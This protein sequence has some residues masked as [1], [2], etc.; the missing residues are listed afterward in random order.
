MDYVITKKQITDYCLSLTAD[1]KSVGTINKY[2]R[3]VTAFARWLNGRG[4]TKETASGWKAHMKE[5]GYAPCTINSMLAAINGFFRFMRWGLRVK[6]LKIQRQ[7]FR[8]TA[9]ELTRAE[10]NKL[11]STA[12][13]SGQERLALIMETLCATG[14]R[15]S[16]LDY[17]TAEA[18]EA[19]R[20]TISLKGKKGKD[21]HYIAT[22]QAMP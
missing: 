21:T 6:F 20:A 15:I 7:M 16:E 17:I 4:V 12:R 3:D 13:K 2:R 10:Y 19:G 22:N 14:I 5:S 8:D 11:L 1:E 18:A 9:K